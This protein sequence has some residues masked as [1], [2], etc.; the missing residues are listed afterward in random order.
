MV[1]CRPSSSDLRA[2]LKWSFKFIEQGHH[3]R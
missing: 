2:G 3:G 1:K